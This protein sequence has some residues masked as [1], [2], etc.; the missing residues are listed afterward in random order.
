MNSLYRGIS[1]AAVFWTTV[2]MSAYTPHETGSRTR[3]GPNESKIQPACRY[4]YG[5]P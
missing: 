2:S 3:A 4:F 1:L 5:I